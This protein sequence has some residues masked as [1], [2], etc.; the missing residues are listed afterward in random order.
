LV[1]G[2][3]G[4]GFTTGDGSGPGRGFSVGDGSGLSGVGSGFATGEGSGF[5]IGDGCGAGLPVWD[6]CGAGLPV[7]V[8]CG[9]GLPVGVGFGAG[10]GAGAGAG[11]GVGFATALAAAWI[12]C[13]C[14]DTTAACAGVPRIPD[15]AVARITPADIRNMPIEVPSIERTR[16]CGSIAG[17]FHVAARRVGI[18]RCEYRVG[19]LHG[20][21]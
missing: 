14:A 11:F 9:A 7:G 2:A 5:R 3:P 21:C 20:G 17:H 8:G 10:F 4:D 6:G 13:C 16:L 18:S 15:T 19:R 1:T 12:E